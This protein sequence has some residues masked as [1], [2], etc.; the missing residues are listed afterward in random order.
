MYVSE[1]ICVWEWEYAYARGE[2]IGMNYVLYGPSYKTA[3]SHS[4]PF[5]LKTPVPVYKQ[6][7]N[8]SYQPALLIL[9]HTSFKQWLATWIFSKWWN[10]SQWMIDVEWS[11]FDR[12]CGGPAQHHRWAGL[13]CAPIKWS[14]QESHSLSEVKLHHDS[15]NQCKLM[16]LGWMSSGIEGVKQRDGLTW[17]T[18][19]TEL[20]GRNV[21]MVCKAFCALDLNYILNRVWY[22]G[23]SA[24]KMNKIKKYI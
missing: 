17:L 8:G 18:N 22:R 16:G 7:M 24:I 1:N 4:E 15:G 10:P 13:H 20:R 6:L 3:G 11:V 21:R 23:L 9:L 12:F 5:A 19:M 2:Y 14:Q